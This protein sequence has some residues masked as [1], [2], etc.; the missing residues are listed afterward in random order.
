MARLG[1]NVVETTFLPKSV[2]FSMQSDTDIENGAIVGKGDLVEGETSIYEADTDYTDGMYL[3]AHPAWSYDTSR[4]VNQNEENF[5]NKAGIP[6]RTYRLE[7][8]MKFKVYNIDVTTPFEIGD[9]V[10]FESGKY[11]KDEGG[12]P[13]LKVVNVEDFGFPFCVGSQGTQNGNF[14]YAVGEQMKKYTIEVVA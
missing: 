2:C 3:V 5:I 11:V 13:K 9:G 6:F 14:G 4:M 1:Y 12:S 10:K 7:K 8:D